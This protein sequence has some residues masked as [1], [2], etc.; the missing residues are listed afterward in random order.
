MKNQALLMLRNANVRHE[1]FNY[2]SLVIISGAG[3]RVIRKRQSKV[4]TPINSE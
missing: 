1:L 4:I 3:M 2:P